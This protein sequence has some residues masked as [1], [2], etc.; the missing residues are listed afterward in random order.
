[1]AEIFDS[2][3]ESNQDQIGG[4]YTGSPQ[5]SEVGQTFKPTQNSELTAVQ[6]YL[7]KLNAPTGTMKAIVYA[8]T[9]TFGA[10]GVPTGAALAESDTI[11]V[12][13]LTS[14]F[15][16]VEFQFSTTIVLTANTPYC[17]VVQYT[18]GDPGNHVR[19]GVDASSPS[20]NGNSLL[21]PGGVWTADTGADVCFYAYRITGG[22]TVTTNPAT[23]ISRTTTTLNGEIVA[24]GGVNATIRGFEYNTVSGI[25]DKI[26]VQNGS[27]STGT[28]S[29]NITG[30]TPNTTYYFRS[31]ATNSSGTVYGSWESFTTS[32]DPY[33]V[34]INSVNRT[35]DILNQTINIEDILNDQQN[36][37]SFVLI[38][39]S[40]N[41]IPDTDDTIT[42]TLSDSTV[43]FS[44]YVQKV[45]LQ[46]QPNGIVAASVQCLDQ[47]WLLDR[48][49]VHKTYEDMTD[50]AIIEDIVSTYC[51][52]F[53][54]T[55][56]NVVLGVTIDQISFNYIQPSQAIRQICD[57]TG[58]NWYI[59]YSKDIHYFP[60]VTN[61]APF[62]I[63]SSSNSYFGLKISKDNTQLKNRVYV[64][65]GTKLS[66]A[67]YYQEKGDGTKVKF[68]L[69]DKPHEVTVKVNGVT[70]TLGIKN[71][72]TSG[73]DWYLN[74]QEK[75]VEQDSGGA[76]LATT[77]TLRVDYSYDIPILVAVENQASIL[78][79]GVKEFAIFDKSITTS[80]AARDRAS[81]EL[82][83]YAQ[84]IIEGSFNTYTSGFV[85]GQYININ[86]SEYDVNADYIVQRVIA[87]SLGG[88]LYVYEVSIASAKTM[89]I[90]RFLIE[91]LEANKN[92]IELDNNESV[93][94]LLGLTDSLIA[95]S[96]T[97][98][99][100]IDSAGPYRTWCADSL[101]ATSTRFRWNLAEWGGS[102]LL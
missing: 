60:L 96:I 101:E 74:F 38:D 9:G 77:D 17:V 56:T 93:D 1:M 64:R 79:N 39:R 15:Q 18:G 4:I 88:G 97:E 23:S 5:G 52:G 78:A 40:G 71:I 36:T 30:L 14:G 35:T 66:D 12:S 57:L 81:A 98:S 87:K 26:T 89:G 13:T 94:E 32:S 76:V 3:S 29:A 59:D 99:L 102:G 6:F 34:S 16:L 10:G 20:H 58:R 72:D 53:G 11:D 82:T 25:A 8:H 48:N 70:K 37:L 22:L 42:I 68:V 2:Y 67:T 45:E 47:A 55:T 46:K 54:I 85:S 83:D 33:N 21:K 28:F 91:L 80:Q 84:D 51:S 31:Y 19:I 69:P 41:G 24:T 75:Y 100:T 62:N 92:L 65:G 95:D 90:I 86:L 61:V 50:K 27:F 73:F 49:L 7:A 63:T 44:G 43:I